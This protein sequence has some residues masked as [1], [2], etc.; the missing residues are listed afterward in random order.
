MARAPFRAE[1]DVGGV[2]GAGGARPLRCAGLVDAESFGE[3]RCGEP[4][5]ERQQC[6]VATGAPGDAVGRQA[7]AQVLGGDV[8]AAL[9]AREQLAEILDVQLPL[10]M[11][12]RQPVERVIPRP[13]LQRAA[14]V[15]RSIGHGHR[16]DDSPGVGD[17]L[18]TTAVTGA[19]RRCRTGPPRCAL[20]VKRADRRWRALQ[21]AAIPQHGRRYGRRS[22]GIASIPTCSRSMRCG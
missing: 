8:G 12:G 17:V 14:C 20:L 11:S 22:G 19:G 1:P 18:T 13:T 21:P 7:L 16:P 5:G 10:A 4:A 6:A 2:G 15:L 9:A 3:D